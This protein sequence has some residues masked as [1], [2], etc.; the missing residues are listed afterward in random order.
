MPSNCMRY[1]NW[2][3]LSR[4]G[5]FQAAALAG[6]VLFT[7][8][9]LM[10]ATR[11]QEE[12][13][14][15]Q[16]EK[17]NDLETNISA[18]LAVPKTPRSMPGPYPGVVSEAFHPQATTE[19]KPNG[20]IGALMLAAAM[21]DLTGAKDERDAWASLFEPEDYVGLKI[22]PVGG[23]LMGTGYDL[24][25]TI[26]ASLEAVGV[27][28]ENIVFID[29]YYE[30]MIKTGYSPQRFPGI[31]IECHHRFVEENG[32]KVP[33]GLD[34]LD[35]DVYY[36]AEHAVPDDKNEMEYML[37]G[38]TKSY[39]PKYLTQGVDKVINIPTL[40]DHPVSMVSL[41]FKNLSYG[42][43]N[44]CVRGHD[45]I[46]RYIVETCA[47]PPLRDRVVLNI[48]D[49]MRAQCYGGPAPN[50]RYMWAHN[51]IMASTDP[52][53]IDSVGVDYVLAKQIEMGVV[54]TEDKEDVIKKHDF[55]ARAENLGLGVYKGRDIDHRKITLG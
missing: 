24:I 10:A 3:R 28:R 45:F 39:F 33:S 12:N 44:N 55:L 52:A 5:F 23:R 30:D 2:Y 53:A 34:L 50:A 32:K 9:R 49:G 37:T 25:G 48:V 20:E 15:P 16:L 22:N 36:E 7:P 18:A 51:S 8:L 43:T 54:K 42:C 47:F 6:A 1:N 14:F 41:S 17:I 11:R 19:L 38:G 35:M 46:N 31:R 4:R 29:H 27:Q 26:I 13:Q 40:K 21:K